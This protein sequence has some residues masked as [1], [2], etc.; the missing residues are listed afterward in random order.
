[1]KK[2]L[3]LLFSIYFFVLQP[4]IIGV[5]RWQANFFRLGG[6]NLLAI[7]LIGMLYSKADGEKAEVHEHEKKSEVINEAKVSF[8]EHFRAVVKERKKKS[9]LLFPFIVGFIVTIII[10]FM[11]PYNSVAIR[12][13]LLY[14]LILWFVVFL[15][16]TIGF[17]HRISKWFWSLRGTRI[18][19]ILLVFAVALTA[20]DYF[21]VH[22]DFNASFE[23]YLAQ[24]L[25]GQE[26]IPTDGYVFT[27][28]WTVLWSGLGNTT[29]TQEVSS[30]VFSGMMGN[31][32]VQEN[33]WTVLWTS[34]DTTNT[35]QLTTSNTPT[36][37]NQKLMDAVIY[38]LKK[39]NIPLI[40]TQDISFTYVTFKNPYYSQWRTAYASK[41]IGKST[42]PSKYIICESYIVMKWLL[43]NRWVKYT[44][45]TVLGN[46][47]AEAAKRNVLNGCVKGKIV[48]DKTL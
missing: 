44:S 29:G 11:F 13:V 39:N 3:F 10:F 8:Q 37:G 16:L 15:L 7:V 46:F 48:T 28:E 47:R 1:M 40:T 9:E 24:N 17:K 12:V 38:L 42:N 34:T 14:A 30:D 41:L 18:Y 43:E 4:L 22:N 19:L 6:I 26:T 45:A 5:L 2:N 25:L 36:I 23:D 35:E 21:Q 27:G 33:T 20:Y 31:T 32:D